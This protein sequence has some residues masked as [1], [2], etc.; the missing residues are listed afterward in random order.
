[1]KRFQ[2]SPYCVGVAGFADDEES[3]FARCQGCADLLYEGLVNPLIN[4]AAYDR[5]GH[6]PDGYPDDWEHNGEQAAQ[7]ATPYS[8][9]FDSALNFV[10][11]VH[12]ALCILD[13]NSRIVQV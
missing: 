6:A 12:L 5:P 13:Y 2:C 3:R 1:M 9:Y 4:H 11:D 8:T 10:L 7:H